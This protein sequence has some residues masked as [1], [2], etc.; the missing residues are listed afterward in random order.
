MSA[1]EQPG[2]SA[3]MS[4]AASRPDV[5]GHHV[6]L[7]RTPQPE[8]FRLRSTHEHRLAQ[9]RSVVPVTGSAPPV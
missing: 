1:V 3:S 5:L 2:T 6:R 4:E 9:L 7:A 8:P